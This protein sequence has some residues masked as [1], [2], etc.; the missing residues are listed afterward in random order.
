M[1]GETI[2]KLRRAD[3]LSQSDVAR[4][5]DISVSFLSLIERGKREPTLSVLRRLAGALN[6][7]FGLLLAS[8][9]ATPGDG[10]DDGDPR[11]MA[12][13]RLVDAVRLQLL[14][15]VAES[16]QTSLFANR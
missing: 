11:A 4:E 1:L 3:G 6:A 15:Q 2:R 12:I 13:A 8:A 7:P 9:L 16:K 5:A 14:A 10:V